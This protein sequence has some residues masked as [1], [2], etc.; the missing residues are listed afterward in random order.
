MEELLV[1]EKPVVKAVDDHDLVK[2]YFGEANTDGHQAIPEITREEMKEAEHELL[3]LNGLDRNIPAENF[4]SSLTEKEHGSHS[5][6][7]IFI[8]SMHADVDINPDIAA[9]LIKT[10]VKVLSALNTFTNLEF[11]SYDPELQTVFIR[12][13]PTRYTS[14]DWMLIGLNREFFI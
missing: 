9:N 4:L 14:K 7:S 6:R 8:E 13:T 3:D 11:I 12:K 10:S 5:L 2:F 1:L